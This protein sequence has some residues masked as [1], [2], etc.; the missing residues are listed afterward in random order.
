MMY[1][2]AILS[3]TQP[4]H[5]GSALLAPMKFQYHIR[6]E[7]SSV[8]SG[9]RNGIKYGPTVQRFSGSAVQRS[10]GTAVLWYN[11]FAVRGLRLKCNLFAFDILKLCI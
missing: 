1:T 4:V 2:S 11:G 9:G 8:V 3:I 10:N 7:A 5:S 6:W